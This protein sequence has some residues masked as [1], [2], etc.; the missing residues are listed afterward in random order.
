MSSTSPSGIVNV[1]N[2]DRQECCMA[3]L[4]F[5][6]VL[7]EQDCGHILSLFMAPL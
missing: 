1:R 6:A 4:S 5:E 7:P 2:A 3:L